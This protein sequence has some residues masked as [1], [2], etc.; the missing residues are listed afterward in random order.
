MPT[1]PEYI[2]QWRNQE[3]SGKLLMRLLV[4]H[5]G[6]ILPVSESAAAEMLDTNAASRLQYNRDS[7]GVNRL[8]MFSSPET[9]TAYR[10]NSGQQNVEQHT[11]TTTGRWVFRLPLEGIDE[12]WIDPLTANDI[13]YSKEQ[14]DL[15]RKMGAA[16]EVEQALTALRQGAAPDT[17]LKVV[18]NYPSYWVP[19]GMHGESMRLM[20]APDDK[21]RK[22]AALF[23]SEETLAAFLPQ[24]RAFAAPDQ[25]VER[26]FK[27]E[28]LFPILMKMAI[29]G[30]VFNCGGGPVIPVAFAKGF[31]QIACEA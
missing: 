6:W 8:M 14:F 31:A 21:G 7:K 15:L 24:V 28:D 26:I 9:F 16:I 18:K 22:L 23:T 1:I 12:I 11:L 2:V 10:Q 19:V 3:I 27:G 20:F 30:M 5:S 4:S 13:L 25:V 29:D 17:A